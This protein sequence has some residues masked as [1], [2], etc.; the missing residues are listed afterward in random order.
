MVA[1]SNTMIISF[2][3]NSR[4]HSNLNFTIMYI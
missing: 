4:A 3:T 2:V 1:E